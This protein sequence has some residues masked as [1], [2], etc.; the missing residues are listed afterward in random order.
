MEI[1]L[2]WLG[3]HHGALTYRALRDALGADES[4]DAAA[5][6]LAGLPSGSAPPALLHST[7]W[8]YDDGRVVLTYA[9]ACDPT[10]RRGRALRPVTAARSG[11]PLAPCPPAVS[12]VQV[13]S[14]A[15]RHLAMLRITD[16]Y[17]AAAVGPE[18]WDLLAAY[19]IA[20][21]GELLLQ[22]V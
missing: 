21:A 8:R 15:C 6:R 19:E 14:H 13:A 5:R 4:P 1:E 22:H 17:V 3:V 18:F 11:D 10:P 2:L 7:S 20:P 9:G 16:G 12:L